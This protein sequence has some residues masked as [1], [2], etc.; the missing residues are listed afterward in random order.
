VRLFLQG[1]EPK[2]IARAGYHSLSSIE[3]YVTTFARVVFLAHKGYGTDEIAFHPPLSGFGRRPSPTLRG[4]SQPTLR[5]TTLA[6]NSRSAARWPAG[7]GLAA[8]DVRVGEEFGQVESLHSGVGGNALTLG[9][10][11][12]ATIGL[13]FT[14]D[15]DVADGDLHGVPE[16]T[17]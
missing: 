3:N 8:T 11:S 17:P 12:Q 4:V 5:P 7:E 9:F 14:G 13:F 15:A 1:K 16:C 2:E 10:E 6:G